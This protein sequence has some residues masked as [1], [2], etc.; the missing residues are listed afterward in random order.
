[1]KEPPKRCVFQGQLMC[2]VWAQAPSL[3]WHTALPCLARIFRKIARTNSELLGKA[4]E[5][6][7]H[8]S[9]RH[10]HGKHRDQSQHLQ[11]KDENVSITLQFLNTVSCKF[12]LRYNQTQLSVHFALIYFPQKLQTPSWPIQQGSLVSADGYMCTEHLTLQ[13]VLSWTCKTKDIMYWC[14]TQL[15]LQL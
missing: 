5:M 13:P 15:L 8:K 4:S 1:M 12:M 11:Q 7:Q 10:S 14:N 3:R 9:G 6:K 2:P